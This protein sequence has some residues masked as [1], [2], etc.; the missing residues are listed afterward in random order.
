M[1]NIN[2]TRNSN[3]TNEIDNNNN[4]KTTNETKKFMLAPGQQYYQQRYISSLSPSFATKS[5]LDVNINPANKIRINKIN[6]TK[7]ASINETFTDTINRY[8]HKFN[9]NDKKHIVSSD[10]TNHKLNYKLSQRNY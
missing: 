5:S 9:N 6:L 2:N 3:I 8:H 7:V 10:N 1:E 4:N